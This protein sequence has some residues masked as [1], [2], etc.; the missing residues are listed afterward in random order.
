MENQEVTQK[1]EKKVSIPLIFDEFESGKEVADKLIRQYHTELA[2]ANI[3]FICRNKSAKKGGRKVPG[4]VSKMGGKYK[5]LTNCDFVIEVSLEFWNE[6]APEKRMAL[7]DHLLEW[8]FGEED[9]KTGD[10]KWKLR[11]PEVQE[12]S[13][14]VSR[15]GNWTDELHEFERSVKSHT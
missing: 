12:F 15:H 8:C 11:A 9:E 5:H 7:I 1:K 14:I 3:R 2:S 13:E 6:F 10:M 4:T